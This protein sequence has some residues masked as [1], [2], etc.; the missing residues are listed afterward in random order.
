MAKVVGQPTIHPFYE[1]KL[2]NLMKLTDTD[3][4]V[5]WHIG[6][7]EGLKKKMGGRADVLVLD[8]HE[9]K[10]INE[11]VYPTPKN[12]KRKRTLGNFTISKRRQT[13]TTATN[14]SHDGTDETS[15]STTTDIRQ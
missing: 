13:T 1:K 14:S 15:I 7:R 8:E 4:I 5:E 6:S 11:T 12:A 9:L 2:Y 3:A 10:Y